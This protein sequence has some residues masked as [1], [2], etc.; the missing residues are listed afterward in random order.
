MCSNV[1]FCEKRR[2]K[3][4]NNYL[5]LALSSQN[6]PPLCDSKGPQKLLATVLYCLRFA[7]KPNSARPNPVFFHI[8]ELPQKKPKT[9]MKRHR[10]APREIPSPSYLW[11]PVCCEIP[12]PIP[13]VC[14]PHEMP[15][16]PRLWPHSALSPKARSAINERTSQTDTDRQDPHTQHAPKN[17]T[18]MTSSF[19]RRDSGQERAKGLIRQK[20]GPTAP[21]KRLLHFAEAGEKAACALP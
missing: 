2:G 1:N 18:G 16:F 13:I 9:T 6:P 21:L 7:P 10:S 4:C 20:T 12:S 11:F 19:I 14:G 17:H 3:H 5:S 8:I 15:P